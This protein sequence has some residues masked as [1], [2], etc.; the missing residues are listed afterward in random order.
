V[1]SRP[2]ASVVHGVAAD[3]KSIPSVDRLLRHPATVQLLRSHGHR[4][5]RDTTRE[6][7]ESLRERAGQGSLQAAELEL[8]HLA[9]VVERRCDA[10]LASSLR[11]VINLTG[12]VIHTNLGRAPLPALALERI[13]ALS[14]SP[15]NLE[16]DLER[17]ARGDRDSLVEALLC[18]LTGAQAA[19]VV[20]N[21]AAAVLL[22]IAA[23]ARDREVLVSRG[24]LVEIGGAFRMPDVMASA[25]ARLVEVGTTN[26]THPADYERAIGAQSAMLMKVHTS[27]YTIE[28]FT[29]GSRRSRIATGCLWRA[30]SAAD[31]CSTCA[32]SDC[33][34]SR[35]RRTSWL[36]GAT[37]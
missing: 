30:T 3:F 16:Y 37:W 18:R 1:N 35:C 10:Q 26:R 11:A 25:G 22:M 9:S 15:N 29:S 28:G 12:T 31:H 21:N 20:N 24:E 14:A 17:G 32:H 2:T 19:T 6:V 33:R 8:D 13:Q 5:I 36:L 7:L 23:L 27:N 34:T 4:L